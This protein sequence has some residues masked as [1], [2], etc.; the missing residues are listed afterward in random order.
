LITK[1]FNS[2]DTLERPYNLDLQKNNNISINQ[3]LKDFEKE[4]AQNQSLK[5]PFDVPV[6]QI[7]THLDD[8]FVYVEDKLQNNDNLLSSVMKLH[9]QN[10]DN[11]LTSV[12]LVKP[13][14]ERRFNVTKVEFMKTVDYVLSF[15][16]KSLVLMTTNNV[17][18][19]MYFYSL[20]ERFTPNFQKKN[21]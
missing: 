8:G 21:T 16:A 7:N 15:G 3:F 2:I 9:P 12:M 11:L 4:I 5:D 10:N 19:T 14:S 18:K 1:L 13:T 20:I 6:I 17:V